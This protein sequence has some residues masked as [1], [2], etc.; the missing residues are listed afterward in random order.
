MTPYTLETILLVGMFVAMMWTLIHIIFLL[1]RDSKELKKALEM[2][3][4]ESVNDGKRK[5]RDKKL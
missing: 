2:Y 3:L 5:A 4:E 1:N